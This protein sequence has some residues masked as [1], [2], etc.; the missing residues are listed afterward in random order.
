MQTRIRS[1]TYQT[2]SLGLH[3]PDRGQRQRDLQP[4]GRGVE[5]AEAESAELRDVRPQ[6][7]LWTLPA[8]AAEK[9]EAE[10]SPRNPGQRR[11]PRQ[12]L[13]RSRLLPDRP[14]HREEQRRLARIPG[15]SGTGGDNTYK[16]KFA[17]EG[18]GLHSTEVA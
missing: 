1:K 9:I 3:R 15:G 5:A 7:E 11:V 13:R 10:G 2:L 16:L 14:V 6:P 17:V 18:G 8:R 12:A 4:F